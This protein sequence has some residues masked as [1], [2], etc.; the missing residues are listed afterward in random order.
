MRYFNAAGADLDNEIGEL[1]NPEPHL[2]P[3]ILDAALHPNKKVEIYGTNYDTPD[4]TCIRDY[5]HVSD[6]AE[7]HVLSLNYLLAKQQNDVFNIGNGQGFSVKEVIDTVKK[8]TNV[9]INY[10]KQ[11]RRPGDP[12]ILIANA[13]KIKNILGWNPQF[14]ELYSIIKTAW[15]WSK[16][17]ELNYQ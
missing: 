10:V 17:E 1:H 6:L 5:I 8:V 14:T 3:R 9:D 13:M 15:N 12:A 16:K 2:I 11:N 7:A 4:G